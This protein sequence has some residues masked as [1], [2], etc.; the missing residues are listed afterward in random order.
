MPWSAITLSDGNIAPAIAFGSASRR[1]PG[2]ENKSVD[3]LLGALGSGFKHLDTAQ[4]ESLVN[5][6]FTSECILEYGNESDVGQAIRESKLAR[7][8]IF[9]T[10]KWSDGSM[11]ARQACEASLKA[12]GVKYIDLYV[13]HHTWTCNGDIA[14]AWRQME[15]IKE[16]GLASSIGLSA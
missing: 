6:T 14:G 5:L 13:I 1:S 10:T 15:E 9:I 2:A 7:D 4:R 3:H 16:A 8:E 12:L 11:P